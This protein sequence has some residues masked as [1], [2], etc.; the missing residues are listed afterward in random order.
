MSGMGGRA[1]MA[2]VSWV[3]G[4]SGGSL[5]SILGLSSQPMRQVSYGCCRYAGPRVEIVS[6][7]LRMLEC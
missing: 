4:L 5:D 3:N 2:I 6:R 1:M 7:G